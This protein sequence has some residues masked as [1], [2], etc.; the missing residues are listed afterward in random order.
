MSF[1]EN[2]DFDDLLLQRATESDLNDIVNFLMR[3]FLHNEPLNKSIHLTESD[4][5]NLFI[6]LSQAGIASSLSYLLRTPCGK[7]A[8]VRLASILDRPEKENLV[9]YLLVKL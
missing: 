5:D 2:P 8:A 1:N 7:I 6:G 9:R 3:D 4:A